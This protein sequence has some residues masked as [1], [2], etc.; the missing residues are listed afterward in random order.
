[1]TDTQQARKS[2]RNDYR[3][4]RRAVPRREAAI[5]ARRMARQV[6]A[7]AEFRRAKHIALYLACDGEIDTWTIVRKLWRLNKRCYL[8][9]VHDGKTMRFYRLRQNAAVCLRRWSL[10]EPESTREPVNP[11]QIDLV[12]LPLVAFDDNGNR[13]GRGGGYYDRYLGKLRRH[14]QS[15]TTRTRRPALY[16]LAYDA[17]RCAQIPAA[18]WDVPLDGVFTERQTARFTHS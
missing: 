5:A 13:L 10:P 4:W 14:R 1:M 2:L 9:I 15:T 11:A 17:Q 6:F 18:E 3:H 7:S 16:G 12:L 8:P